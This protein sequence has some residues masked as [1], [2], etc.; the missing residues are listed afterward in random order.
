[1]G[2]VAV[3]GAWRP[4][5]MSALN[6]VMAHQPGDPMDADPS[7]FGTQGGMHTWTAV[8]RAG[9]GMDPANV[10]RQ[11]AV[12]HMACTLRTVPPRLVAAGA[13][14]QHSAQGPHRVGVSMVLDEA[15]SHLGGTEK[16]PMAFFKMSRSI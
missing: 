7:P 9:F 13:H 3:G 10:T 4:A 12:G 14:L 15:E 1:M 2:M 5:F 6:A 16:M 8:D 11:A